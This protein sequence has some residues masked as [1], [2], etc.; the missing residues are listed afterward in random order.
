[1]TRTFPRMNLAKLALYVI[2]SLVVAPWWG[3]QP[4]AAQDLPAPETISCIGLMDESVRITWKDNASDETEWRVYRKVGSGDW[5]RIATLDEDSWRYVDEED[6]GPDVDLTD[7]LY[8]VRS[9]RADDDTLSAASDECNGRR[10]YETEDVRVFYGVEGVDA[11]PDIDG[12]DVCLA[13]Q[14]D[15]AGRNVF[16]VRAGD[17]AQDTIDTLERLGF[18]TSVADHPWESVDKVPFGVTWCDGGGCAKSWERLFMVAPRMLERPPLAMDGAP[19]AWVVTLHEV[20]H[21]QQY[22]YHEY[23]DDPGRKWIFEGQARSVQDKLCLGADPDNCLDFDDTA[24][25][26]ASYIGEVGEYMDNPSQPINRASYN[27]VLFWTYLVEKYGTAPNDPVEGGMNLMVKFWEQASQEPV[28]D[29]I[30]VLNDTLA[31]LGHSETFHDVWKDFAVA[32]YAKDYAGTA[33]QEAKYHYQ[34]IDR[35]GATYRKVKIYNDTRALGP[36]DQ[37]VLSGESVPSWAARYYEVQPDATVPIIDIEVTQEAPAPVH[38]TMLAIKNNEIVK[39]EHW[40]G[41]NLQYSLVNNDYDRVALIVASFEADANYRVS[42]NGQAPTLNILAPTQAEKARVGDPAAPDKFRVV[43]ELLAPNGTPLAGVELDQFE[44]QVGAEA[45][46][47]NAVLNA[48]TIMGQHWFTILAPTQSS[49][50]TYDLVVDYGD[51]LS[52]FQSNAVDYQ[53]RDDADSMIVIDRS[54]SMA[55]DNKMAAAQEAA[56]LYVDSWRQGDQLGVVSFNDTASIDLALSA[57]TDSPVGGSR[58]TA[59]AE[60][61]A[62]TPTGGT[63]IGDALRA[64]WDELQD[65]GA[66]NHDWAMVLLSDGQE[67]AG[68]ES[69]S[70]LIGELKD[71]DGKRPVVHAVAVGPDADRYLMQRVSNVTGGTFQYVSLPAG[72]VQGA[73]ADTGNLFL[74]LAARYRMVATKVIGQQQVYSQDGTVG[75]DGNQPSDFQPVQVDVPL[76]NGATELVLTLNWDG[77]IDSATLYDASNDVVAPFQTDDQHIVWRVAGPA[78]GTWRL[79]IEPNI[80]SGGEFVTEADFFVQASLRS[81]VTMEA[82]LVSPVGYPA[83]GL[84]V[85]FLVSLTGNAPITGATVTAVVEPQSIFGSPATLTLYDDGA[86]GDGAAGDG[87]YGAAYY[88]TNVDAPY[89]VTLTADGTSPLSGPFH[90]EEFFS[91]YPEHTDSD[92]D[93]L[94]DGWEEFYGTDPGV[95]DATLDVDLDALQNLAES[96]EGTDPFN[97]DTD[98]DGE[99]DYSDPDPL[100]PTVGGMTPPWLAA[101]ARDGAVVL[102]YTRPDD[103]ARIWVYRGPDVNGP[104]SNIGSVFGP[105]VTGVYT[106]TGVTNDQTYCYI[107]WARDYNFHETV[108]PAAA[109]ATPRTDPWPPHGWIEIEDS[110]G[111]GLVPSA[112]VTLNLWASD[113]VDPHEDSELILPPE[114]SASG[115]VEMMISN[116]G[117]MAGGVWEPYATSKAWTLAESSGLAYVFAKFRD[118]AG[119]ESEIEAATIYIGQK[120]GTEPTRVYLPLIQRND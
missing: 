52:A 61:D 67:T 95:N 43:V 108:T 8:R 22:Q 88:D 42:I 74:D 18:T 44:F 89:N 23:L 37:V 9:Y 115:V 109:C 99:S 103:Y 119:N 79:I 76:E 65:D 31:E 69:F 106:D 46:P 38:Y 98:G 107:I 80:Y 101:E 68:S 21:L 105:D 49:G 82:Y 27:A 97:W 32:N 26:A 59:L 29:G 34:D 118:A 30:A 104:F 24:T 57:W 51:A 91:F 55:D 3:A 28:R 47:A 83:A 13:D 58:A 92:G 1:M 112:Q 54:G 100:D 16:A 4:V 71:E 114:T 39:E 102:D 50:G 110:N 96:Q 2:L 90:R 87:I 117:D 5:T 73:R 60:I 14:Q 81:Q 70:T 64:A 94:S 40:D 78:G 12:R 93:G 86:H 25:G 62:L 53:P 41:G 15:S 19:D 17:A 77:L 7:R 45:V 120:P 11:C 6:L 10:V 85:W 33:Q 48:A 36:N 63:A 66:E 56:K 20:F 113:S 72:A 75:G 116:S 35:D 111:D 84:P